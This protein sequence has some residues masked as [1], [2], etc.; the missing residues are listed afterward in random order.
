MA[1][2]TPPPLN[3]PAGL[4]MLEPSA[5]KTKITEGALSTPQPT[6]SV[7][8]SMSTDMNQNVG[9]SYRTA[10]TGETGN[11]R[12]GEF[13]IEMT[14]DDEDVGF[15]EEEDA[16]CPVIRLTKEE[17]ARLRSPWRQT[18]IIKNTEANKDT[19]ETGNDISIMEGA[20]ANGRIGSQK[21][22]EQTSRS[23]GLIR[24]E[25]VEN[26]G[27]WMVASRQRRRVINNQGKRDQREAKHGK[28]FQQPKKGSV[29]GYQQDRGTRFQVLTENN[30][31][32]EI[33]DLDNVELTSENRQPV[34][35]DAYESTPGRNQSQ[36]N[37]GKRPAVQV[38][39]RQIEGNNNHG[40]HKERQA[41]AGKSRDREEGSESGSRN[42]AA[43]SEEH[44]GFQ[45]NKQGVMNVQRIPND[46]F[47]NNIEDAIQIIIWNCQGAA[48]KGFLRAAKW[49]IQS[50][51]PDISCLLETKTSGMNANKVCQSLDFDNWNRIEAVGFS[52]G[53]W[54]LWN[55]SVEV[56]ISATN[57]QFMVMEVRLDSRN[58]FSLAVVY[59][60]PTRHLRRKLW[61][62]LRRD[63]VGIIT[64]WITAG[65][66]NSV[67]H[68]DE[69]SN[70]DQF[71]Y[72]RCSN[73]NEWIFDEG[74]LDMGFSGQCFTW[75]RG[76]EGTTFK[77][78]RLD[79]ALCSIDWLDKNIDTDVRHL[80]AINSDHC[81]LLLS[82]GNIRTT[83]RTGFKYQGAWASH[84]NF[85]NVINKTWDPNCTVQ[86][87]SKNMAAAF[88]NWNRDTFGN[89]Y[90]RKKTLTRRLEGVQEARGISEL[91]NIPRSYDLGKYLGVP[92]I[93]GR[94]TNDMFGA[95]LDRLDA[96]LE[97]WRT[98][99]LTMAGRRILAQSALTTIPY[100]VMQST[101]LPTGVLEAIDRKVRGFLWGS[102]RKGG[103]NI[104]GYRKGASN[105]W[106]GI[107][108]VMPMIEAGIHC[109]VHNGQMTRFWLDTWIGEKP[110]CDLV[111]DFGTRHD[112]HA[113]V[114]ELWNGSRGWNW[115]KIPNLPPNIIS[116]MQ[117]QVMELDTNTPDEFY[118][119]HD[120]TG[121]WVL[122]RG[123]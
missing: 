68:R 17:K 43:E 58:K 53:I 72:H 49:F 18:L 74:L 61:S 35:R 84:T 63:K 82:F 1:E 83:R 115:E 28:E 92:S 20:T 51:K 60:S 45:G 36:G 22:V 52:R 101:M 12:S 64:P 32:M 37:R 107:M 56:T 38:N 54:T 73:F 23:E 5:K 41:H 71:D 46:S 76:N 81:P 47:G 80:T 15:D 86:A 122:G 123:Q 31:Y 8:R 94:V 118:W 75:K 104:F 108:T 6:P 114:A 30:P 102:T 25:V 95:I 4:D 110:L 3:D 33:Q 96:K 98:K 11:E 112:P 111:Q 70:P 13:E 24:P 103:K 85:M 55:N 16:E 117:C 88:D 78:A 105:A 50:H 77:G 48:S 34:S 7:E 119:K 116:F 106:R 93:H 57:P 62:A 97:G 39:E 59:A 21:G 19:G 67:M 9:I 14:S 89:I 27:A 99:L 121:V 87:N 79:R 10:L 90:Q 109:R 26:Y 44:V 91:A 120:P 113:T 2:E 69:V 29:P 100:Y 40:K 42:R 66:F 65:D